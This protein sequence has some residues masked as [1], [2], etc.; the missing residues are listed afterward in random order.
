MKLLPG[1]ASITKIN[2]GKPFLK[3]AGG[4][5]QLLPKIDMCLPKDIN[6]Q[7]EITYIEPFIG[8]GAVLFHMLQK[9]PNIKKAVINDINPRLIKTYITIKER[10][11]QLIEKLLFLQEAYRRLT[12][13]ENRKEFYLSVRDRFN[14][15][16]LCDTEQ[17]ANMIF[18]NRTCFNGLY[19]E[20]SKGLFNVP[21]G[22][23][24]NPTICD[25]EL[26]MAD[27][28]L[29][30][31]VTILNGDFSG[32]EKYRE[33]YTIFYFDP[34][35]RPM[36]A[37]SSFNSYVKELF[38]DEEQNRLK[39]FFT[40]LSNEGCYVLL[41]NSDSKATNPKDVD[42][43]T[44]YQDFIIERVYAKRAINANPAK[45]GKITE[46]LIRN[47]KEIKGAE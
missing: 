9:Y 43:S 14:T 15:P 13:E 41:S 37:T 34:P 40:L 2:I 10:P 24:A 20:N 6:L 39:N 7:R 1:M 35:Y 8:G 47:Y 25:S 3:W 33:G 5:T 32:T 36:S 30:Q 29:L 31:N 12:N 38:N 22:R 42:I 11:T 23:Y 28:K 16:N 17:S 4:K 44:L 19:R 45:R 26:I 18:L 21:F 46:L 27:S